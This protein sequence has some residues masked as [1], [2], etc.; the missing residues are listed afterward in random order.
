MLPWIWLTSSAGPTDVVLDQV[1]TFEH[2]DLRHPGTHLHGHEVAADRLAVEF[3]AP[4]LLEHRIVELSIGAPALPTATSAT[5]LLAVA[6]ACPG[7]RRPLAAATLD[8]AAV[9]LRRTPRRSSGATATA[10]SLLPAGLRARLCRCVGTRRTRRRAGRHRHRVTDARLADQGL[11]RGL[12]RRPPLAH[13]LGKLHVVPIPG[14]ILGEPFDESSDGSS[15]DP[16]RRIHCPDG[17]V[18]RVNPDGA[19]SPM[20]RWCQPRTPR[21]PRNVRAPSVG[22]LA[23][24]PADADGD[25]VSDGVLSATSAGVSVSAWSMVEAI[26]SPG[27]CRVGAP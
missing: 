15:D 8:R 25:G 27:S 26:P 12:G 13:R 19:S 6:A 3:A 10:T 21:R 18:R 1:P 20:D 11:L 16:Q 23:V 17:A 2:T 5:T 22:A 14:R 4:A 24:S 7:V 9:G